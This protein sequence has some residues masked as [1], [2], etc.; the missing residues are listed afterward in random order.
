MPRVV[1]DA[2]S[3]LPQRSGIGSYV[4]SLLRDLVP[5]APRD[6]RF[7]IL[8]HPSRTAPIVDDPRVEEVTRG[9]E[10]K[11][12]RTFLTLGIRDR[13]FAD[14]DLFHAPHEVFPRELRCP[15]VV[16]LHDLMWSEH[17]DL[18]SAFAPVRFFNGLWYRGHYRR[19]FERA[20]RLIAISEA[21]RAA[22]GRVSPT[23]LPKTRV[24]RHGANDVRAESGATRSSIEHLVAAGLR[25]VLVVGQ[26]SPYKNHAAMLRAF[27][28][29]S[30]DAPDT[31]LVLVRRFHRV[32][33][34]MLDLLER[35]AVRARV[36]ALPFVSDAELDA[37]YRHAEAL[38]FAS[39]YEGFGLPALEAM[40]MGLPVLGSTADAVAEVTGDAALLVDPRDHAALTEGI[41]QLLADA[42]LRADLSRRGRVR[43]SELTW[44]R[45]AEETLAVYRELLG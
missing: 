14:A 19:A 35:P 11:S 45:C 7:T 2:R 34:E 4:E 29:A 40:A 13:G 43:A 24:V 6:H 20:E 23:Q 17:P 1:I 25:Y 44:R 21:T 18:A 9:G 10:S 15:L 37:L 28:E 38:L 39:L 12:V 27:V 22:I 8:R 16:T 5:I 30:I 41:R 26:G 32:D 36:I 33:R 31:R 3:V 42:D